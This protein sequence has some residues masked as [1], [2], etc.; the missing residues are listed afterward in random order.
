MQLTAIVDTGTSVSAIASR[1]VERLCL[2]PVG[3]MRVNDKDGAQQPTTLCA[4]DLILNG[5][6]GMRIRVAVLPIPG[7]DI[8]LGMDVLSLCSFQMGQLKSGGYGVTI[9]LP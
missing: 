4:A 1:H 3:T 2:E 6:I 7:D 8:L 9:A 5:N